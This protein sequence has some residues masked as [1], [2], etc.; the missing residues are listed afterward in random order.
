MI[1]LWPY[2]YYYSNNFWQDHNKKP[3][4]EIIFVYANK[5]AKKVLEDTIKK[6][7]EREDNLSFHLTSWEEIKTQG[8]KREVLHK[9]EV[10]NEI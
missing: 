8:M 4:P 2:H 3:F 1:L 10:K 7:L 5:N 6:I 9:A